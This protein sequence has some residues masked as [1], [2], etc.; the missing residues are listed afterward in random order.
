[1]R[2]MDSAY[3][4]VV[5]SVPQGIVPLSGPSERVLAAELL[6]RRELD[7]P[8]EAEIACEHDLRDNFMWGAD[9]PHPEGTWPRTTAASRATFAG[10]DHDDVRARIGQTAARVY[11][12]DHAALTKLARRIGP[13]PDVIDEPLDTIPDTF[14]GFAFRRFGKF[15]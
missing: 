13:F 1:M 3:K 8:P 4:E 2:D 15:A 6:R 7:E 10:M 11:G 9:Y 5:P 14:V 12:F